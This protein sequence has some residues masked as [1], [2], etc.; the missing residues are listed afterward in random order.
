MKSKI[1]QNAIAFVLAGGVGARLHPLTRDRAKPAVPFGGK[2][3]VV[4]FTL[5]NC[6][7]SGVRRIFLLPQYKSFSLQ[8][9]TIDAWSIFSAELGEF[10]SHLSPQMRVGEDWYKGTAD[11]V[12]QNLYHLEELDAEYILILSGDHIYKMDY[13]HFIRYHQK[14]RADITISAIEVDL[15][16]AH[17]FGVIQVDESGRV[18]GF[19]EKPEHP[20]AIPGKR[21]KAFVSMGVYV[22][23]RQALIDVLNKDA[24]LETSRHDFGRDIIPFM[25]PDHRVFVYRFGMVGGKDAD[26]WRD[27]GT[28]DAYYQAN[29]DLASVSPIFNLYDKSWPIRT[30]EGQYPPAKTVFADEDKGRAGKALDSI[31]CSGVIISGGRVER[32]I[33]SPGVRVNSY[34][35]VESSILFHNVVVGMRAK[36]KRAIIDK[37]VRVPDGMKIGYDLEKDRQQFFVSDR[38]V[39]VIPKGAILKNL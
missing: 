28:I 6:I 12:Y 32:S 10:M 37:G 11:A 29:M 35:Q 19:E 22:F 17:R 36:V 5:S 15:R 1:I 18:I 39:V 27:I 14:K 33:L 30:Y 25:Y 3:R 9:H 24:V 23:N 2:Y 13:G 7:N 38:G 26:Y 21:G 4:E 31:I 8:R 34:A 20:K 16:E